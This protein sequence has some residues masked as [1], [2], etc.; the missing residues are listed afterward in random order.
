MNLVK[1]INSSVL[2]RWFLFAIN[3]A[4]K[5]HRLILAVLHISLSST[6]TGN[7]F[8][9]SKAVEPFVVHCIFQVDSLAWIFVQQL[10]KNV[11]ALGWI[12]FPAREI[13]FKFFIKGHLDGFF[14]RLVIKRKR[15]W[16][17]CIN[18]TPETPQI[19]SNA[20][21]LFLQDFRSNIS[22][23]TKWFRSFFVW[24]NHFC[25]TEIHKFWNWLFRIITHHDIFKFQIPMNYTQW[26]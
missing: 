9:V 16:Q 11:L 3:F 5:G 7:W 6:R 17:K 13:K 15:T 2:S 25:K 4:F 20:I 14:L 8:M 18:N 10:T 24:P 26:M 19:T 23:S 12:V 1:F 22:K 21:R